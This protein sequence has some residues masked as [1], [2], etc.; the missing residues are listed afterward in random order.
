MKNALLV[1]AFFA[2]IAG[3]TSPHE[4]LYIYNSQV[5]T[6]HQVSE[7]EMGHFAERGYDKVLVL[8]E[9]ANSQQDKVNTQI[10]DICK[11]K[12]LQCNFLTV[13]GEGDPDFNSLRAAYRGYNGGKFLTI[14][15][16]AERTA[17]FLGT[18]NLLEHHG[19]DESLNAILEA[20]GV[21]NSATAKA[22][23]A[24]ASA[25]AKAV[26]TTVR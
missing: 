16:N 4:G 8:N 2:F 5:Y 20:L 25:A 26:S 19:N 11:R 10:N 1:S 23:L 24:K 12:S 21:S 18:V 15:N 17:V 7:F 14:S 9:E 22:T 13:K 6:T 3:C